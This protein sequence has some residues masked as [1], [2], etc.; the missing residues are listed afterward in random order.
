VNKDD[1]EQLRSNEVTLSN[2]GQI[3]NWTPGVEVSAK[4]FDRCRQMSISD[5][6]SLQW[7]LQHFYGLWL[8]LRQTGG[9]A[10]RNLARLIPYLSNLYIVNDTFDFS[11]LFWC[12]SPSHLP[13][14]KPSTLH[15]LIYLYISLF[16]TPASGTTTAS[17]Q[18]PIQ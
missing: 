15:S 12:P 8:W 17:H 10:L 1:A 13:Y 2:W 9:E 6:S 7:P 18:Y 3:K 16:D 14:P 5:A 11:Q 4:C